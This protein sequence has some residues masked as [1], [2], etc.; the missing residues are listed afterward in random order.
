MSGIN[1]AADADLK[2]I[3]R[4]QQAG[5]KRGDILFYS[6]EYMHQAQNSKRSL[7]GGKSIKP[8]ITLTD[9]LDLLRWL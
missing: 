2:V 8:D 5:W 1:E 9:K 7:R 3:G 4:L 6:Q